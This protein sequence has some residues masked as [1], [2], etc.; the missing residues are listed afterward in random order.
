MPFHPW[1]ISELT[2]HHFVV[3]RPKRSMSLNEL[4]LMKA[5]T[6]AASN[7]R[8]EPRYMCASIQVR[9]TAK[10]RNMWHH[11]ITG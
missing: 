6:I 5:G 7:H 1:F 2:G 9:R 11:Y 3:T 10:L 8:H 4:T